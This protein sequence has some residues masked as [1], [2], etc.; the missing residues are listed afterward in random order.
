MD[1]CQC[2]CC[3][4]CSSPCFLFYC[5]LGNV[6]W[7][8]R[9]IDY[10]KGTGKKRQ[11]FGQYCFWKSIDPNSLLNRHFYDCWVD[12]YGSNHPPFWGARRTVFFGKNL[13]LHRCHWGAYFGILHDGKQHHSRRR[14][15]PSCHVCDGFTVHFE[16]SFRRGVHPLF[17]HGYGRRC[18][19]N[20]LVI[21]D[22]WSV[23]F[24]FFLVR[25]I[26]LKTDLERL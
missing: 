5:R 26:G 23:H 24:F 14:E 19:G 17:K 12:F 18:L 16:S 11:T 4:Q 8:G 13:L 10:F 15:T 22:L 7:Y 20:N 9:W 6:H 21:R 3:H 1:R 2:H 25:S